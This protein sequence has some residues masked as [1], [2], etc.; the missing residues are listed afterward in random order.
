[1]MS[2]SRIVDTLWTIRSFKQVCS[3]S[4]RMLKK[5]QEGDNVRDHLKFAGNRR[6]FIG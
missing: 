3:Y 1:M 4:E 2:E 6:M 5:A